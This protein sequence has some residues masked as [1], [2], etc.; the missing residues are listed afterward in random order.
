MRCLL[1]THVWLWM[2]LAPDRLNVETRTALGNPH[3]QVLLSVASA[4]EVA[5]KSSIG[6]LPLPGTVDD[7]V[8]NSIRDFDLTIVPIALRHVVISAALPFHH[9]DP[10]DR[11]LVAQ[12]QV[13]GAILV[14]ADEQ[15]RRYGGALLW[16]I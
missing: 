15:I 5:L 8:R 14:T 9:K 11:V 4:W 13:E 6:R 16:A 1:D 3:N 10:F 2:L 12:S 7:L